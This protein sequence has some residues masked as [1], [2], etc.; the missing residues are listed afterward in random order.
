MYRKYWGLLPAH[1]PGI[2]NYV[3][4]ATLVFRDPYQIHNLVPVQ[5]KLDV[6]DS[7]TAYNEH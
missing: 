1:V 3:C 6:L 2:I 4:V 7:Y 5:H